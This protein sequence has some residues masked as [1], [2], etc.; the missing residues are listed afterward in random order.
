[1]KTLYIFCSII[2]FISP[3]SVK[4]Y[5]SDTI[6]VSDKITAYLLFDEPVSLVDLGSNDFMAKIEGS[7]VF[8]KAKKPN[9]LITP[10]YIVSGAD[11]RVIF[12]AYCHQPEKVLFDFRKV[13]DNKESESKDKNFSKIKKRLLKLMAY[14]PS[15]Y[16]GIKQDFISFKLVNIMNDEKA[17]YL[18]FKIKNN[19][20]IIYNTDF[21][22]FEVAEF[23]RK[24]WFSKKKENRRPID[25]ITSSGIRDIP[26][27]SSAYFYYAIPI[28]AVG[29]QGKLIVT[30]RERN[31]VRTLIL[32]LPSKYMAKADLY[33]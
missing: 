27:Y 10:A 14:E 24:R 16:E 1:M 12:L 11:T 28:Y 32:E 15:N 19:S 13:A 29:K 17:I 18:R 5:S 22:G 25:P 6:Q 21:T 20:S 26:S 23:Y 7:S 9:A 31:G 4:A 30:L 8:V 3:A 2:A 33:H